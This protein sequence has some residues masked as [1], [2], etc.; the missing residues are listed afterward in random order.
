MPPK[1]PAACAMASATAWSSRMSS[2]SGR[3]LPPAASIASAALW[4]VPG[5]FGWGTLLLAAMTTL[6]PSR[7]ARS[8]MARPMPREAPVMN[9]VLPDSVLMG[10]GPPCV[11]TGIP[12]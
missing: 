3:A 4:M 11:V 7:A 2:L 8:P 6:A 9:R 5:S 1:C 12:V 10:K